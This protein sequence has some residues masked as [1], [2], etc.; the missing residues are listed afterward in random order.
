MTCATA[1]A[2]TAPLTPA[3]T[4][5]RTTAFYLLASITVSFLAGSA[6]PTPLYPLYQA[7]W[8]FSPVTVTVV[9]ASTRS[10]CSSRCSWPAGCP[11]MSDA[12]PS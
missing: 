12:S 9:S 7:K 3:G 8:G 2:P 1:A 10:P 5:S 11:I 6:A 4:L